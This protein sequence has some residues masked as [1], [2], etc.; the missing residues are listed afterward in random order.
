[1]GAGAAAVASVGLLGRVDVGSGVGPAVGVVAEQLAGR[2]ARAGVGVGAG[3]GA[4]VVMRGARWVCAGTA[5]GEATQEALMVT[6]GV[7]LVQGAGAIVGACAGAMAGVCAEVGVGASAG[8]G[9]GAGEGARAGAGVG[10]GARAGAEVAVGGTT[11]MDRAWPPWLDMAMWTI[12][13]LL[14]VARLQQ[15]WNKIMGKL[16]F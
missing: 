7:R 12:V 13:R 2:G 15:E 5:I 14:H 1:M 3:P 4:N 8:A 6:V 16:A 10:P 9:V 11:W